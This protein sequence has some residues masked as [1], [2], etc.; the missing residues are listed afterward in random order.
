MKYLNSIY[1]EI[2]ECQD[3]Y[4]CVRQCPVK[5]IRIKDGHA[6]IIPELCVLC[7]HCVAVCPVEAK[8]VIPEV[9]YVLNFEEL[10]ALFIAKDIEVAQMEEK[11]I[12]TPAQNQGRGFPVT[13][14]VA[15]AIES[16]LNK[17]NSG[18]ELIPVQ[19]SGINKKSLRILK[20]YAKG[21]C[22]GNLVEVMACEGGCVN[23]PCVISNPKISTRRIKKLIGKES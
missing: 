16:Y 19:I 20:S 5:A 9:D 10:G 3:C 11:D 7:G 15:A 6:D 14:G 22:P 13:G 12:E 8:K 1:T 4:K 18:L 23:G 17:N 2:A 21:N